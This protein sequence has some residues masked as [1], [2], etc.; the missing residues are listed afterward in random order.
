MNDV[1]SGKLQA[2]LRKKL[3]CYLT[4]MAVV[5]VA[6]IV[7][8]VTVALTCPV[9]IPVAAAMGLVTA[10]LGIGIY[11]LIQSAVLPLL[12]TD[13]L[14]QQLLQK[15]AEPFAGIFRGFPA[16]KGLK[17]G[18]MMHRFLLDEG[19][20][21][22]K[23]PVYRELCIPAVFGKP[24]LQEGASISGC[25]VG[26][27]IVSAPFPVEDTLKPTQGRY[28]VS[29][30]VVLVILAASLV[31][32]GSIYGAANAPA[33]TLN[34]AVCTPAHH[35]QTG[36]ELAG[37]MALDSVEVSFSYTNTLEAETVAMYLATF[38]S[39]DADILIL[40]GD[41]FAAVFENEG[42]PLSAAEIENALGFTPRYTQDASGHMTGVVLYIPED[43]A[44]NA[45]FPKL[46]DWIAVEKDV[47]LVAAIRYESPYGESG[48]ANLALVQL[49]TYLSDK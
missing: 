14:M 46:P 15:K 44:Y 30:S 41:Q 8:E 10:M 4:A 25:T 40:N 19:T 35:E 23:E 49:L 17:S 29:S 16:G 45:N 28:Q 38:G 12:R 22:G 48:G 42:W 31:L 5:T 13:K 6:V 9:T 37:A 36:A 21:V 27:V 3:W 33:N 18:I 24:H 7:G 2:R 1:Y 26:N 43:T 11:A 34:V 47:A 20:L 39:M 32:W